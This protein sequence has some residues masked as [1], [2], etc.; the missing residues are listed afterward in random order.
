M[1]YNF[2]EKR[3]TGGVKGLKDH[4]AR[5]YVNVGQCAKVPDEV[6][7]EC[8]DYLKKFDTTKEVTQRNMEEM[9]GNFSYYGSQHEG[10]SSG[11]HLVSSNQGTRDLQPPTA[12]KEL[13][14][15]VCLDIAR[16]I[17]EN[18]ISFNVVRSS[19]WINMLRSVGSYERGL[20]LLSMYELR[21]WMLN[22]EDAQLL[23]E[24]L[25]EVVEDM[26][27]AL[28]VQVV[29]DNASVYKAAVRIL[30]EKRPH[31]YWTPCA[32]HCI[33]LMLER[34]GQLPWHKSTLLKAKFKFKE[35]RQPLEAMFAPEE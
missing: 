3:I 19:S 4:L 22:E 12:T 8:T 16:L 18:G 14:N 25:D 27:D 13:R 32:A 23:F 1:K 2:C 30:M 10:S 6:K 29:T 7:K 5:T 28:V 33:D 9:I 20:Q 21:T 35:L 31:L 24:M 17:Y 15:R 26:G 11:S 34:L